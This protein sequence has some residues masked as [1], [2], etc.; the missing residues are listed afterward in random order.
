MKRTVFLFVVL[1][2]AVSVFFVGKLLVTKA[3]AK[4]SAMRLCAYTGGCR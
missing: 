1:F 3:A 2:C 4:A